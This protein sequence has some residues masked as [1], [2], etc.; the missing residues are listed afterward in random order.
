MNNESHFCSEESTLAEYN[1]LVDIRDLLDS[2]SELPFHI[3]YAIGKNIEKR[4]FT[5]Q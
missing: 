5:A 4:I 2:I 3:Q 1:R